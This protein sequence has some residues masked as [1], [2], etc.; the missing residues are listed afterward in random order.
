MAKISTPASFDCKPQGHLIN[1]LK[2]TRDH[3]PNFALFLGAGASVTSHVEPVSSMLEKWRSQHHQMYGKPDNLETYLKNQTW[4]KA[5]NEYSLLFEDLYDQP[6]QRREFIECCL[7]EANPSWGYI[8]LV[9]LLEQGVFNTVFTTNFDDLLNEACYLFSQN[10]R[11]IVCAHDSSIRSVRITSKRPKIIKLHGDFLFDNIKNTITELESLENNMKEKF[12]QYATEFGFIFVGYSGRDRSVMDCLNI[13]LSQEVNFP[14]GV[15]WCIRKGSEISED[16]QMLSRYP[17]FKLIEIDGFDELFAEVHEELGFQLQAE[18]SDPYGALVKRLNTLI[19]DVNVPTNPNSIIMRHIRL[20]GD[21]INSPARQPAD[22]A[23]PSPDSKPDSDRER[24]VPY[25]ML[26]Q[27]SQR[28]GKFEDAMRYLISENKVRPSV[29][30]LMSLLKLMCREKL[31]GFLPEVMTLIRNSRREIGGSPADTF[32]MSL[33]L[34]LAGKY[35]EADEVL[36]IG[37]EIAK[38]KSD[39]YYTEDYYVLNKLQIKVYQHI[40][41]SADERSKL[42]EMTKSGIELTRLAAH[43]LL[44]NYSAAKQLLQVAFERRVVEP[45]EEMLEWPIIKLLTPHFTIDELPKSSSSARP[46]S[47]AVRSGA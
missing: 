39:P 12:K 25:L 19:Q 37:H 24:N 13:L 31:F 32:D 46:G 9:H 26:S 47:T 16:V 15:Y 14:H 36:D 4:Y 29:K 18:M 45:P 42:L 6:S 30:I 17:R 22:F 34:I 1:I 10:V 20:I 27:I 41:L 44:G 7:K 3:H 5:P 28:D 11:P 8:Y 43:I 21:R 2:N 35:A 33:P 40:E 38:S 23:H